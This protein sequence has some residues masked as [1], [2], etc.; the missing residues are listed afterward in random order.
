[1]QTP[2]ALKPEFLK[3]GFKLVKEKKLTITDDVELAQ[4][5]SI[6]VQIIKGMDNN[7]KVTTPIDYLIAKYIYE[8]TL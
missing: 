7:I 1:M 4:L 8:K 2:Q 3:H 6:K 5:L